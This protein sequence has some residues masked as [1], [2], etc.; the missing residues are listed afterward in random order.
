VDIYGYDFDAVALQVVLVNRDGFEDVTAAV[1]ETSNYHLALN[2]ENGAVP[3]SSTSLS[4][5]LA[6][7]HVIHHSISLMRP[8]TPLCSSRVEVIS[9]G[10]TA[11]YLPPKNVEKLFTRPETKMWADA[12][13]DYESNELDVTICATASDQPGDA[14]LLGGCTKHFL[15]T[16]DPD[17]VIDGVVGNSSSRVS[18]VRSSRAT[19][20]TNGTRNG[21]VDQ[22][23][24]SDA[25]PDSAT[26]E[27]AITARLN[28]VR[29]ASSE[30]DGCISPMAYL[31][32]KRSG[33]ASP[34]TRRASIRSSKRSTP[35]S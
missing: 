27:P 26:S 29:V 7:G 8:T 33:V 9:A 30:Q 23:T 34:A 1:G 4:L 3:F 2:I 28:E 20:V 35:P 12:M 16:T 31:E 6:W 15:Y 25:R 32:A 13:L 18:I 24:F 19:D 22:W 14:T 11:S 21:P 17:R 10:Q 5:G